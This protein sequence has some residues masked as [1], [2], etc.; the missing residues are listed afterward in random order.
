MKVIK[1]DLID[2]VVSVY[3][4]TKTTIQGRVESKIID[5]AEVLGPPL[6]RFVDVVADTANSVVPIIS[7]M[8]PN[9]RLFH[10]GAET[11]GISSLSCHTVD[12]NTGAVTFNGI[13]RMNL[14]QLQ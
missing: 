4:Q 9:G 1:A 5:G 10:I 2:D 12:L 11:G 8:T 13:I 6:N 3:D 14:L 7:H